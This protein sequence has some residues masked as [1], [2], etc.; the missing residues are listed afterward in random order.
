M[1]SITLLLS[2]FIIMSSRRP[3]SFVFFNEEHD[4]SHIKQAV[5]RALTAGTFTP[6][7]IT[8][9]CCERIVFQASDGFTVGPK[10]PKMCHLDVLS[11][12]YFSITLN[13]VNISP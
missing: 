1:T 2:V 13:V 10:G 12:D 6:S 3:N 11:F 9:T 5:E 4:I 7:R 8:I